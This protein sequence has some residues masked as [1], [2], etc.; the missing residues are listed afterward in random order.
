MDSQQHQPT[1]TL[2]SV[3]PVYSGAAY[4]E[5]LVEQL[6]LLRQQWANDNSP[7][8]LSEAIFVDDGAEDNSPAILDELSKR[9]DWVHVINLSRNFGQHP[10]TI[11]GILH[12]S[13]DWVVTLDEDL[14]HQPNEIPRLF[15]AILEG[16]QDIAYARAPSAVHE[17][18]FRDLGSRGFKYLMTKATG[19]PLIRN[20]NSYR[21]IRGPIARAA[22]SVCGHETYFDIALSWFTQRVKTVTVELKDERVVSGKRSGYSPRKL[23]S[24][25]RRMIVSAHSKFLRIGALI[26]LSALLLAFCYGLLILFQKLLFTIGMDVKGWTSIFLSILFF[27]G[28]IS[29]MIGV[30]LEYLSVILLHIQGKPTFFVIDRNSDSDLADYFRS[31]PS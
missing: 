15:N 6:D 26:G 30:V 10:A 5:T 17:N 12:S 9:H 31:K 14:Q 28:I 2:S 29:F 16:S 19:N 8:T 25:A 20:F 24:H 1:L 22:A 18:W 7:I 23:L 11:A 13:G 3:T 4:L 27:G 21:L